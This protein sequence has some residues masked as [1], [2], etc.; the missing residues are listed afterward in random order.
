MLL[1]K[2]WQQSLIVHVAHLNILVWSEFL[3]L[4]EDDKFILELRE[5]VKFIHTDLDILNEN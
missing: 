2:L 5:K 3:K 4:L 1:V